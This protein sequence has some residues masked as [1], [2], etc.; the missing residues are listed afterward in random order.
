M[1]G[2]PKMQ[3]KARF[4]LV[5]QLRGVAVVLMIIY[6]FSYNLNYFKFIKVELFRDPFW[7]TFPRVI[8]FL[9]LFVVGLSLPLAHP[10]NRSFHHKKYLLRIGKILAGA[11]AISLGTYLMFPSR[12]VYFGTLHCIAVCSLMVY[13]IIYRPKLALGIGLAILPAWLMGY[14][15]PWI[16][17]PHLSM[18]YIPSLPWVSIVCLGL[19][20]HSIGFHRLRI[21]LPEFISS[22]LEFLGI[23]SFLIYLVHQPI[24]FGIVFGLSQLF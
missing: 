24:L 16:K 10:E 21:P 2:Q 5:D 19:F 12:W 17:L 8:V 22:P 4:P 3:E 13:P 15:Y 14:E 6:H 9:F 18:D 7:W 20:A 1:D 23:H 11:M